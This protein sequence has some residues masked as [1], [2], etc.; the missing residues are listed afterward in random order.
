MVNLDQ[1]VK[2]EEFDEFVRIYL[3]SGDIEE[4]EKG[5][6]FSAIQTSGSEYYKHK[7]EV[8]EE[9]SLT[10]VSDDDVT[11]LT[12][13][14]DEEI[15]PNEALSDANINNRQLEGSQIKDWLSSKTKEELIE[16]LKVL[17]K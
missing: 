1:I 5:S 2:L 16:L 17:E 6:F 3:T 10:G 4:V 12:G 13:L 14:Y 11:D 9:T 15:V 7:D 8:S